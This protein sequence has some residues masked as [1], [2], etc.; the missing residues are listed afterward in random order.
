MRRTRGERR[1][2]NLRKRRQKYNKLRARGGRSIYD[3]DSQNWRRAKSDSP[4][5]RWAYDPD[6]TY[7]Y[8]W[9]EKEAKF[10]TWSDKEKKSLQEAKD[11]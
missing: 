6:N 1:D 2:N 7:T 9:F 8:G 5:P 10:G 3:S 4:W 11:V